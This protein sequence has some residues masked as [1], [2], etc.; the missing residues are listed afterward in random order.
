[1][2][3]L[4]TGRTVLTTSMSIRAFVR[5]SALVEE[6]LLRKGHRLVIQSSQYLVVAD[7]YSKF[8]IVW[9]LNDVNCQD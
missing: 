5:F 1:M 7:Y 6:G 3:G 4:N 8:P 2:H 9:K